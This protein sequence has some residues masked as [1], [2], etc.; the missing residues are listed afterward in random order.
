MLLNWKEIDLIL[1]ELSLEGSI[2]QQVHQPVHSVILFDLYRPRDSLTLYVSLSPSSCRIHSAERKFTNPKKIQRFAGLLRSYV[3]GGRIMRAYQIG[4]ERIVKLEVRKEERDTL[5]WI[6]LWGGAAN[7]IVTEENGTILDACYRR[8][9]R[10]EISGG[11]YNPEKNRDIKPG[12][13]KGE[14]YRIR[15]LPGEGPFNKKI[16]DYFFSQED[17][18]RKKKLYDS[19]THALNEN[20]S[21]LCALYEKTVKQIAEYDNFERFREMGDIV[22]SNLHNIGKGD[23]WLET[24]DFFS[25]NKMIAIEL[26]PTLSPQDNAKRYYDKYKKA[27]SALRSL[28]QRE[29]RLKRELDAVRKKRALLQHDD[30]LETLSSLKR[31]FRKKPQK[32]PSP[33]RPGLAFFSGD[34]Q[35]IVGKTGRE[36]DLLLRKYVRGNDY[37]FHIRDYPG[38]YVFVR[39]KTGRSIPLQT[40]LDAGNLAVFY[41][42]GKESG[43]GDVY[44]TRVK[45][46]H[47]VKKGKVGMVIPT[48]EKNLYVVLDMRRI[49][50]LKKLKPLY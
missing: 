37:W 46:L 41:S 24:Y 16:G 32:T 35:I 38:A 45:Y 48:Q 18:D 5:I 6:R 39:S 13:E 3:K 40:M 43:K 23:K 19:I 50:K 49:E 1:S 20:E 31:T 8:P 11:F 47:R 28:E 12:V 2:I 42:K 7:M 10:G 4:C 26:N 44:Y 15:E 27:K 14:K 33:G 25:N 17:G 36:N 21:Y 34:F 9:K 29:K 22:A 30:S